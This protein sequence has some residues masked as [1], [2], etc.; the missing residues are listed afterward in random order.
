LPKPKSP[1]DLVWDEVVAHEWPGGRPVRA[2]FDLLLKA[3]SATPKGTVL[4]AAGAQADVWERVVT[5]AWPEARVVVT[6]EG[7]D[8][9]AE[10]ARLSTLA[11]F[12][13]VVQAADVDG[14]T[15][16]RTF[17]RTFWH[18]RTGGI[19]L[20]PR[21]VPVDLDAVPPS[22][23]ERIPTPNEDGLADP[24]YVGDVWQLVAEG[25]TR[26][27][28]DFR[29]AGDDDA[30]FTDVDGV[31]RHV[32]EIR[33]VSKML[34]LRTE[35]RTQ[36]KLTEDEADAVLIARPE[37]GREVSEVP[38]ATVH[39]RAAYIHNTPTDPYFSPTMTSPR[40]RL[41]RYERP[42]CSRGQIVTT[43]DLL[44][45][46][47][48][49]H[50]LYPRLTNIY[51]EESAPRFGYVRR[52][53]SAP[54]ELPGVWFHLDNEW[55]GHFG[56]MLTDQLG[57][58]WAWDEVKQRE[59]DAKILLTLQHDREQPVMHQWEID[60][61]DTFGITPDDVHVFTNPCRPEVLYSATSMFSLA[62]YVHPDITEVWRKTGDALAG[63]ASPGP[64]PARLFCTRPTT[65]KRP[66][67]NTK[68]VEGL[69]RRH[70]FDVI[71]PAEHS[72]PDQVAMFRAA[73][74][75]GGFLGSGLFT[76]AFCPSPKPA[77]TVGPATYNARNEHL[78]CAVLGHPLV[79]AWT[80]PAFSS[81]FTVDM[82]TEGRFLEE[83]LSQLPP[84]SA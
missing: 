36:A 62:D 42:I 35:H 43:G 53:I 58:M 57:R 25:E 71:D 83:H 11:P 46:D 3:M 45:P 70:G 9:S 12:D 1:L 44:W 20:T 19:Y 82:E 33:V 2:F 17:Q 74:A 23:P 30:S 14:G 79:T 37:L 49:R 24:P 15:Q 55:P 5:S 31:G 34:W 75:V 60:F 4:V 39:A 8:E 27:L 26:R 18:L 63:R 67:H 13:V 59:P 80:G 22:A 81:G 72:L 68:E 69:F 51:V 64:W 47:T 52:D 61:F 65:L 28:E 38:G 7:D 29:D 41:R 54:E 73:E 77:F 48:F 78:I 21:M 50:H 56:H 6:R 66:C 16:G 76:L 32:R 84:L 10:H 40:L